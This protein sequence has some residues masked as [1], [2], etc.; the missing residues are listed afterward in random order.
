MWEV[1]PSKLIAKY[2]ATGECPIAV[3]RELKR[4]TVDDPEKISHDTVIDLLQRY[5]TALPDG[6]LG[7]TQIKKYYGDRIEEIRQMASKAD[8]DRAKL[9][10]MVSTCLSHS[11]QIQADNYL[12]LHKNT[13][14]MTEYANRK[15]HNKIDQ[16][17]KSSNLGKKPEDAILPTNPT[18]KIGRALHQLAVQGKTLPKA[19]TRSPTPNK[20]RGRGN[21]S[22]PYSKRNNNFNNNGNNHNSNYTERKPTGQNNQR[23]RGQNSRGGYKNQ[24]GRALQFNKPANDQKSES[25]VEIVPKY[26]VTKIPQKLRHFAS[27]DSTTPN[28][29]QQLT[30]QCETE[31]LIIDLD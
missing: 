4:K 10:T 30:N 23:G 14:A 28:L 15:I 16:M 21:K 25:Q 29:R 31:N 11:D 8:Y 18:G 20:F 27:E 12:T 19:W 26:D 2:Q 17:F 5:Q 9:L 7:M 3:Y 6:E 1:V 13:P 24:G 22:T